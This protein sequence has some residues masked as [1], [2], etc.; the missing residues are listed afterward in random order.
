MNS[1]HLLNYQ[2]RV[3]ESKYTYLNWTASED[4]V[5]YFRR[6]GIKV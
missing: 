3:D 2:L 1:K 6:Q 5:V 4:R